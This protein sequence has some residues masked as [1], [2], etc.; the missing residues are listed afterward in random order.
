MNVKYTT[1][2]VIICV[3]TLKVHTAAAATPAISLNPTDERA[4]VS[5]YTGVIC[6]TSASQYLLLN[7]SINLYFRHMARKKVEKTDSKYLQQIYVYKT[8]P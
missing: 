2:V 8:T 7:Q 5:T 1:L 6:T 4:R 3:T